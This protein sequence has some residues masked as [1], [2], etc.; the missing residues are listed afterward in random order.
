MDPLASVSEIDSA[1][2]TRSREIGS[3]EVIAKAIL[4]FPDSLAI[5]TSFQREGLVVLDLVLG[6]APR[7]PVLTI[8][9]GRLP[10]ATY[11]IIAEV[12]KRYNTTVELITPD[13]AEVES[14]ISLYGRD[15]FEESV[16]NRMLCC[17][18]RKVR[19]LERYM[20]R[21]PGI[22][23]YFIGLRRGQSETRANVEI[24]DRSTDPFRISAIADW[25]A[26]DVARYTRENGLPEHSLYAAGYT[27][28]GCDPCTRAVTAGEGER[29]GRWWWESEAD[30]ECGIHFTA[31]GRAERAVDVLLRDV[32]SN[33]K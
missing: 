29:A 15:L 14:M 33:S 3:R 16:P 9:T 1:D 6:I 8:D 2:E 12:E 27:S 23:A 11:D 21:N 22:S 4:D 20:T 24:V 28:I 26:A 5:L 32:L 17:Q 25:S 10:A 13:A 19:P 30:K 31:D 18:L 7:T